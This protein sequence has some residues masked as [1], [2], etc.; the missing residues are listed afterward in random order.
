MKKTMLKLIVFGSLLLSL[1]IM[2]VRF[3]M[4]YKR[5]RKIKVPFGITQ[6][7]LE[8]MIDKMEAVD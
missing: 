8:K 5:H 6:K 2:K 1:Y 7:V 3:F 4:Q